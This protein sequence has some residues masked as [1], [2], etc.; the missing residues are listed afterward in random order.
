MKKN[1]WDFCA[2]F[3][4][5]FTAKNQA[6]YQQFYQLAEPAVQD[7]AVLELAAGTGEAARRLAAKAQYWEAT[8]A[9]PQMIA[10]AADKNTSDQVRFA[11]ANMFRLPYADEKFDV[12]IVANA[13]HI[14]SEPEKALAEIRR[15]LKKDGLL[16]APTFTHA[17]NNFLGKIKAFVMK[18]IGFPLQSKW[19]NCQYLNFLQ[20]NGWQIKKSLVIKAA[21][22]LSYAECVKQQP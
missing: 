9:S 5:K 21:F 3:Y 1:F 2:P 15:V 20:S 10:I 8:D 13:L 4:D 19:T 12:V 16:I 18:L 14:I 6:A 7:K 11:V 22:P 17:E